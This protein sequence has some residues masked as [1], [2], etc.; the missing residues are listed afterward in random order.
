M[1]AKRDPLSNK[2]MLNDY[3]LLENMPAPGN[4]AGRHM[5]EIMG[6]KPQNPFGDSY[7][8]NQLRNPFINPGFYG[9]R[10]GIMIPQFDQTPR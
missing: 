8:Q 5:G 4:I 10:P 7:I 6:I 1:P 3:S 2:R 9:L